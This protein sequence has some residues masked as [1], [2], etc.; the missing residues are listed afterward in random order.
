MLAITCSS[1]IFHPSVCAPDHSITCC[2]L[3]LFTPIIVSFIVLYR[4]ALLTN[5]I[6]AL[7]DHI[8]CYVVDLDCINLYHIIIDTE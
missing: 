5:C 2:L 7:H 8:E 1:H 3:K 6:V 4:C